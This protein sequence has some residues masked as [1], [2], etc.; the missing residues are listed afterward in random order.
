MSKTLYVFGGAVWP[1][2][3]W[4]AVYSLGYEDTIK[5]EQVNLVEGKNFAPEWLKKT[6]HATLPVL[7][8]GDATLTDTKSTVHWLVTNAPKPAGKSSGTNFIDRIHEDAVDPNFALL[9]ARN[10]EELKAKN[11]GI[12][13]LFIRNRQQALESYAPTAPEF[14]D[15]YTAKIKANGFLNTVYSQSGEIGEPQKIWFTKSQE[16]WVAIRAFILNDIPAALPESG[17]IGGSAPGEDDFHLAAW[18][19]RIAL[20][21]GGTPDADGVLTLKKELGGEEVPAKIVSYWQLWSATPAWKVV[22]KDGL[23]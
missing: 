2:A 15:F 1:S 7:E 20:V 10:E 4:L 3:P 5:I 11:S 14:A 17:Y 23:H 9:S 19:A 22:Y 6:I 12:P 18:L 21:T 13:G 16:A 8:T